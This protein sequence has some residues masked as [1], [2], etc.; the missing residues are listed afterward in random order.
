MDTKKVI[1]SILTSFAFLATLLAGHCQLISSIADVTG[2]Q[3]AALSRK[4]MLQL[5]E[6]VNGCPE[7]SVYF[8]D[9]GMRSFYCHI[10]EVISYE[11]ARSI[12]PVAIFLDGPHAE[13]LDLDNTGSFGHYNPEFVEMLV[14]YGVPG[15]ESE[16]FRK[17]TQIIYDQYVAS[18]ARIMYVTYRKFQKNPELLRQE[19]NILAYKIKSQGKVE[20]LYYEKYFYFMNPGFAENPDGGFEYFVDRGFAGGYDGNVVK[21]AAYFWIRRSLDGTDKAFFRG[22][23]KLMQTYDS[24]YLQL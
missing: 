14:E 12:V 8:P 4:A 2:S 7:G 17:A 23:M 24:A 16:D 6:S 3:V 10:N 9:G 20:R 15:S 18:L 13:N 11:K 19:G 22:L 21:T 1:R 5:P